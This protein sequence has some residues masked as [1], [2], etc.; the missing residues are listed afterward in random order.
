[1]PNFAS[2]GCR[3]PACRT[4]NTDRK[5]TVS[6]HGWRWCKRRCEKLIFHRS[7]HP[8][9]RLLSLTGNASWRPRLKFN[10]IDLC[11][12]VETARRAP[13]PEPAEPLTWCGVPP[14]HAMSDGYPAKPWTIRCSVDLR[15]RGS[16]EVSRGSGVNFDWA[17][18]RSGR[19]PRRRRAAWCWFVGEARANMVNASFSVILCRSIK[20][21]LAC[22]IPARDIMAVR[23]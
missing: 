3:C 11:W 5:T 22:S 21:P 19:A 9:S 4:L 15:Q 18:R 17:V 2:Q 16:D 13:V 14:R 7:R 12:R 1:V 10:D 6:A 8:R 20:M 23:S